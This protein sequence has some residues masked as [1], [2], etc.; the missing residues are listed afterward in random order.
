VV[1]FGRSVKN[2]KKRDGEGGSGGAPEYKKK[3]LGGKGLSLE[4]F[5]GA[6]R[7]KPVVTASQ[8]R[9]CI[10]LFPHLLI[11]FCLSG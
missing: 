1:G 10:F 4:A 5:V 7:T 2:M 8:I 6:N 11:E 3:R 9:K